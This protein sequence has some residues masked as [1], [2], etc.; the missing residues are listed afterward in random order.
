MYN[1]GNHSPS[2]C[3]HIKSVRLKYMPFIRVWRSYI[4]AHKPV[5]SW[6]WVL[7]LGWHEVH[8]HECAWKDRCVVSPS[9]HH[10]DLAHFHLWLVAASTAV[11]LLPVCGLASEPTLSAPRPSQSPV[12][13]QPKY[14]LEGS[15]WAWLL[16]TVLQLARICVSGFSLSISSSKNNLV[17]SHV[18]PAFTS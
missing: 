7:G 12:A 4:F 15:E 8:V 9:F 18:P 1:W 5:S 13:N 16:Y 14:L 17:Q 10:K 11:G 3:I 2:V 6:N